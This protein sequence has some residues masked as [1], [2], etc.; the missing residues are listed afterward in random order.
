MEAS[1][2]NVPLAIFSAHKFFIT[3]VIRRPNVSYN[4][5]LNY[6]DVSILGN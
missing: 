5:L 2:P 1:P 6:Y 3:S 4:V